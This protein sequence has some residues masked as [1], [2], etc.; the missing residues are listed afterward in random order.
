MVAVFKN[1]GNIVTGKAAKVFV[2]IGIAKELSD[3]DP[4]PAKAVEVKPVVIQKAKLKTK[5]GRPPKK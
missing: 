1:N 5:R 2:R 3:I 4:I